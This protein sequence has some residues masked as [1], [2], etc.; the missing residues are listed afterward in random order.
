[1]VIAPPP[2]DSMHL[3]RVSYICMC[4]VCGLGIWDICRPHGPYTYIYIYTGVYVI[5]HLHRMIACILH[6]YLIQ[7][8]MDLGFLSAA[9]T[10]F[11]VCVGR[12]S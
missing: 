1:M 6:A 10:V 9:W 2:H 4:I 3:T 11:N 12:R 5:V 7:V 8:N